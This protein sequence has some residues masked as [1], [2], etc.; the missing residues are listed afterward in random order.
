[1]ASKTS[2]GAPPVVLSPRFYG[3]FLCAWNSAGGL[4]VHLCVRPPIG[5]FRQSGFCWVLGV[6]LREVLMPKL[7]GKPLVSKLLQRCFSFFCE[8][9][10]VSLP[11]S[12]SASEKKNSLTPPCFLLS[13]FPSLASASH[14]AVFASPHAAFASPSPLVLGRLR[15]SEAGVVGYS[16]LAPGEARGRQRPLQLP[17]LKRAN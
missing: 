7:H 9:S 3:S 16:L 2:V 1:M 10:R 14:H 6:K 17:S 8:V 12:F 15:V 5:E 4:A 11:E 13:S